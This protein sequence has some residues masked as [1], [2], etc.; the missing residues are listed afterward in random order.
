MGD[1]IK[2]ALE[3]ALEKAAMLEDL[4]AEEKEEIENKKK[5][6]P[7][8]AKFYQNKLKPE[9]LWE[10]LKGEKNSLLIMVQKN[11]IDSLKFNLKT[12]ELKRRAKAIIA[13]ESLKKEQKVSAIQQGLNILEQVQKKAEAEKNQV[14]NQFKAAIENNPQARTRIIDQGDSKIVLKLSVEDAIEQNPQWKQ[15]ISDMENRY[16]EE[17][18]NII[19]QIKKYV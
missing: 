16:T 11:L 10:K 14:Y 13:I 17:F 18:E 9:D 15:Y 2:T 1:K 12:D 19:K 3:I 4:S 7:I 6:E 8:M 5:L